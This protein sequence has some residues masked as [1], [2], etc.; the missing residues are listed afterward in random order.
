MRGRVKTYK[1]EKGYGFITDSE[2]R[3][4]FFHITQLQSLDKIEI[5]AMV[6]FEVKENEKGLYATDIHI[7]HKVSFISFDNVRIKASNIKNYGMSTWEERYEYKFSDVEMKQRRKEEKKGDKAFRGVYNVVSVF[8][9]G[10]MGFAGL[11]DSETRYKTRKKLYVTTYQNDN[12]E[13][14]DTEVKFNL[15]DKLKELDDCFNG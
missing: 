3:D 12:Y 10:A 1:D 7:I 14:F 2:G 6:E 8:T 11:K 15:E 9:L 5:G 13:F 4:L